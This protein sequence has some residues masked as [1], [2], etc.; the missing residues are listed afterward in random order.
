[1]TKEAINLTSWEDTEW[2]GM[3]FPYAPYWD[4]CEYPEGYGVYKKGKLRFESY[5]EDIQ[6]FGVYREGEFLCSFEPGV[7]FIPTVVDI[8]DV[9]LLDV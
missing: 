2:F 8:Y 4:V 3:S 7:L 6:F 9:G 1:M 5:E